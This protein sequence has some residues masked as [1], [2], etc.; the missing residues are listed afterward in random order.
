MKNIKLFLL[1]T[2]ICLFY[3]IGHGQNVGIGQTVPTNTLHVTPLNTGDDPVRIDGL[4]Y[5]SQSDTSI[6]VVD[7]STGLVRYLYPSDL[8]K[9]L[10]VDFV[11]GPGVTISGDTIFLDLLSGPGISIMGNTITNTSPDLPVSITGAGGSSVSGTYPNYTINSTNYTAGTGIAVSAAGVIT[12]TAQS[13]S[14]SLTGT[15]ATTVTGTHPNFTINST[16][17]VNDA[18]AVIG[19][20]YN[21]GV[22]LS[23]TDLNVIDGGGSQTVS[24]ASIGGD[25]TG[26]TA[27]V[28]LTGGGTSGTPTINAAA[29]NGISVD[30]TADRIQL[31]GNLLKNTTLT[32]GA[33]SLFHDLTTTGDFI[34]S[35]AGIIRMMVEGSNGRVSVGSNQTAGNFNV[36]GTSFYSNDLYL[37]DGSVTGT[38]LIRLFDSSDDGIIDVYRAGAV[39]NRIHGNGNSFINGG[40]LGLGT[41]APAQKLHVV[42]TGRFSALA[43]VGNRMVVANVSGD[44]LTQA[45]PTGDISGVTAGAGLIGGGTTGTPTITASANNGL[46]V[47]AAADR[48]QLGGLLTETTTITNGIY[49]MIHNLNSTGDFLVRDNGTNRFAVLDNGRTAVGGTAT[50]GMFN[51]TG[52]SFFSDDIYLRDGAVG[53]GD[54]LVRMYDS[55]DDGVIDVYQNNVVRARI[56]GNGNSFINGGFLGIGTA[57]P[58]DPLYV[59]ASNHTGAASI[60]LTTGSGPFTSCLESRGIYSGGGGTTGVGT[61]SVATT[62]SLTT[63][64]TQYIQGIRAEAFGFSSGLVGLYSTAERAGSP[65][66]TYGLYSTWTQNNGPAGGSAWA[67]YFAGSVYATG[68][69]T[70][71][72]RE[73]KRNIR[74]SSSAITKLMQLEV[75][76]YEYKTDELTHMNLQKGTHTGFMSDNVK[77]LYPELVR[78]AVQPKADNAPKE[79]KEIEFD[80]VNYP[81]LVPHLVKGTQEQQTE[82]DTLKTKNDALQNEVDFLKSELLKIK[83]ALGIDVEEANTPS[84]ST[85]TQK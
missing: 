4:N 19:N 81:G 7:N 36:T 30:A 22:T 57:N 84:N 32:Y 64:Y 31:G 41:T 33:N 53:S 5:F 74:N 54:Y 50:A 1:F 26:V 45:I 39:V 9:I 51:V 78:F 29:N 34:I 66:Y 68:S 77:T 60:N 14:I 65:A 47:D 3:S 21:T 15:G 43:G 27:G 38:N 12:N 56:N 76:E 37:R 69:F 59:E 16:D 8:K 10:G 44:L 48:I 13:Q 72:F 62:P 18:D 6:V 73:L 80:A 61:W 82:I 46:N 75:M 17:N 40:N 28:G 71:S 55:S 58:A 83:A 11:T 25:V 49:S 23:G 70:P 42:G 79:E 20:E 35:D 2:L 52:N 67:G 63:G 24:L 85:G